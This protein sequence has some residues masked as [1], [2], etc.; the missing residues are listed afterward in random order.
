LGALTRGV[1]LQVGVHTGSISIQEKIEIKKNELEDLLN[2]KVYKEKDCTVLKYEF[3][4]TTDTLRPT[5]IMALPTYIFVKADESI[6]IEYEII[7]N[8]SI[9]NK[10]EPLIYS[11]L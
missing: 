8:Q 4:M 7:S 6:K 5:E 10:F 9:D 1:P 3:P 2:C 11:V